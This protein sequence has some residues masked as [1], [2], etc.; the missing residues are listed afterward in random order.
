MDKVTNLINWFGKYITNSHK[1]DNKIKIIIWKLK[2][3][4]REY[5][6]S[7]VWITITNNNRYVIQTHV[8]LNF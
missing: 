3:N 5:P 2:A 4:I 8:S 7:R 6:I 1:M